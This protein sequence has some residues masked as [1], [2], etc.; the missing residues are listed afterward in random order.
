MGD[1]AGDRNGNDSQTAV[2][3]ALFNYLAQLRSEGKRAESYIEPTTVTDPDTGMETAA[4]INETWLSEKGI[5]RGRFLHIQKGVSDG[6]VEDL[7]IYAPAAADQSDRSVIIYQK[8]RFPFRIYTR[9]R[10]GLTPEIGEVYRQIE[11]MYQEAT[12]WYLPIDATDE[13]FQE[14]ILELTDDDIVRDGE[15][16]AQTEHRQVIDPSLINPPED[17]PAAED[18]P[19]LTTGELSAEWDS[20]AAQE[21]TQEAP[22][23][24]EGLVCIDEDIG[25]G[26]HVV[27][28][29]YIDRR[30]KHKAGK[31]SSRKHVELAMA[32]ALVSCFEH[33]SETDYDHFIVLH[34]GYSLYLGSKDMIEEF[35]EVSED[36]LSE[37][38]AR[39]LVSMLKDVL[40]ET[41]KFDKEDFKKLGRAMLRNGQKYLAMARYCDQN[42]YKMMFFDYP[43]HDEMP[44]SSPAFTSLMDQI[45]H[46][47]FPEKG[48][49]A[50]LCCDDKIVRGIVNQA[51]DTKDKD[52]LAESL[53]SKE[54]SINI[55]GYT[56]LF[57][58]NAAR[59]SFDAYR[60]EI[61]DEITE[62]F[63]RTT[64]L[65]GEGPSSRAS[66]P[67]LPRQ[68]MHPVQ[69]ASQQ[70][71]YRPAEDGQKPQTRRTKAE[72]ED[73]SWDDVA[74]EDEAT[75][76]K[77]GPD[78]EELAKPKGKDASSTDGS[79]KSKV[80]SIDEW[81]RRKAVNGND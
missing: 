5:S 49:T 41:G 6:S 20:P 71:T 60:Q 51:M 74:D 73:F 4:K 54:H 44:L 69:T 42:R 1:N 32:G 18:S 39:S 66:R 33:L 48:R 8:N 61:V 17:E 16:G 19:A 36:R 14:E 78:A 30:P 76:R 80:T 59:N 62:L 45:L 57:V 15:A 50:V 67:I 11:R 40:N 31:M 53:H 37:T 77:C 56:I 34:N 22:R 63:L 58:G 28:L 72:E 79:A 38:D 55:N 81:K 24:L 12:G 64:Q 9:S 65:P 52:V 35:G 27:N 46:K 29:P 3:K 47:V 7:I 68:S 13:P 21:D 75:D 26:F 25:N 43:K 2:Y 23:D 70:E 10:P